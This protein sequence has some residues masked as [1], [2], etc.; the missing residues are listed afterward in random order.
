RR[1]AMSETRVTP[2]RV[3][4]GTL[5]SSAPIGEAAPSTTSG[6]A[7]PELKSDVFAGASAPAQELGAKP[8]DA[9]T[10]TKRIAAD[11]KKLF[12]NEFHTLA[13][14]YRA[15]YGAAIIKK[16]DFGWDI[17]AIEAKAKKDIAKITA[18][19]SRTQDAILAAFQLM[20]HQFINAMKDYHVSMAL[21][22]TG[23]ARIP[24][25]IRPI[26]GSYVISSIDREKLPESDFPFQPGDEILEV[27]GKP[28]KD[29]I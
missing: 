14:R 25:R 6:K 17:D 12:E 7:K 2:Q 15:R 26:E 27:D 5:L 28:V 11:L 20:A 16:R 22:R 29:A 10:A 18:D 1:S 23:A 4:D 9:A 24:F 19:P 13:D 3:T 21:N 8:A